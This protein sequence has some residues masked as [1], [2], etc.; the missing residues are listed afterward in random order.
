MVSKK[1]ILLVLVA[2]ISASCSTT[3]VLSDGE[4]RL[5]KNKVEIT[6][7]DDF[8]PK[9]V[10]KYIKQKSNSYLIFGW[11]PFLNIY[12]WSGRNEDGKMDRFLRK[13]GVAPV[14][15][16]SSQVNASIDNIKRHL[17]YL[18]YYDSSVDYETRTKG[19]KIEVNY[20]VTL[21]KRY[22]IGDITYSIPDG[23]FAE[24]FY[25]DTA[26]ITVKKGD[27]LSE[28]AL[29]KE[30]VRSAAYF[31]QHGYF[32][33]TK[34]Y[35]SFEA[36]TLVKR[37]TADLKEF[38]REYT[39]N[40]TAENAAPHRKYTFGDV[41]IEWDR[42]L[43]FNEKVLRDM[44]TIKP[45]SLYNEQ[46]VN[47]TYARLSNLKVFSGV[48][49]TLNPTDSGVV[50]SNI[51]LTKSKM[52]GFKVNLESSTNSTGLIGVSPQLNYYHKSLF[53]GGE[54][55]NLGFLGNFQFKYNDRN[56]KSNE[57]GVNTSISF[58]QFLGLPNSIF[59]GPNVPRTEISS[60]YNYQNRPEYTRNMISTTF[61]YTGSLMDGRFFYQINPLQAKIVRLTHLDESFYNNLAGNPFLRDAYQNHFDVGTGVMFYY[62]TCS[63]LIPRRSYSYIRYLFDASGNILSMFGSAFKTDEY[64][65]KLIWGTPF[66]QYIRNEVTLGRTLVFGRNDNQAIAM[67]LMGGIGYAYGNSSAM[68][69]EK[70]FY[71][72]GANSMRGWQ[73]RALG[74]GFAQ[75]DSAFVIPSQTGDIK[76][77]ANLEYRFPMFWKV[78]GA[79]FLDV[80]NV[81]TQ[82]EADGDEAVKT[83]FDFKSLSQSIA[84][85][86][87]Y[88]LRLD[89][90]FLIIRLDMGVKLYDPSMPAENRWYPFGYSDDDLDNA[91]TLHF[92]VGYPF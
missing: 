82:R 83:R 11:N 9:E 28:D 35:F 37:D 48:R 8:N 79:V 88:G 66:S 64:G 33:F 74:P 40:Q 63:D 72:G 85:N 77:E 38:V 20:I 75:R 50:N 53:N 10:E 5:A 54:W 27:W 56:V 60:S 22:R 89:L 84:A 47:T 25:A 21:G 69:F 4:Y 1:S 32:G 39:R 17:E 80:G 3:R 67:R 62:T 12:N 6:N 87:G 90:N 46:D 36:D 44:C 57:F 24:D 92:G 7:G 26:N 43:K 68:P 58:P 61:G 45:G 14:V 49:V 78:C 30:T 16:Q 59:Q 19:K 51:S 86:W 42:N 71:S 2:V 13:I 31:R 15:Y 76:L 55:L 23:Q 41:T 18:G 65:S 73:A 34:N 81:W 91:L 52:Q 70:Q 29:E